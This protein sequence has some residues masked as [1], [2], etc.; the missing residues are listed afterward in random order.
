MRRSAGFKSG[1]HWFTIWADQRLPHIRIRFVTRS[2]SAA[3]EKGS[4]A[5]TDKVFS[6]MESVRE[7]IRKE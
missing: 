2:L 7:L 6:K 3:N 4:Q 1:L 5:G